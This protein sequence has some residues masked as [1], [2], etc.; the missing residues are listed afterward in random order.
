MD[1]VRTV[2]FLC[3]R[4]EVNPKQIVVWGGS[5]GGALS[6]V[7]AALDKRVKLCVFDLPFLS[8]FRNYFTLTGFPAHFFQSYAAKNNRP[9]DSIYNVLDYFDIKNF[10]SLVKCPVM[11]ASGLFDETCPPA[12]N[13][14]AYNNIR[15]KRKEFHLMPD[16][17][18]AV[19]AEY[20]QLFFDWT[21][22]HLKKK[23]FRFFG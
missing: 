9:M 2:D 16:T 20:W 6:L 3:T 4:P 18:H 1:C 21:R 14:A 15:S 10:A 17:G 8:D 13:F 11:M 7:T 22:Q 19:T 12:I 5:M 23:R